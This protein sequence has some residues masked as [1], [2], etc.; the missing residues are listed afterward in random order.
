MHIHTLSY[1]SETTTTTL[2]S[3]FGSS[4]GHSWPGLSQWLS[5]PLWVWVKA[6]RAARHVWPDAFAAQRVRTCCAEDVGSSMRRVL[7]RDE[8]ATAVD[9]VQHVP[10]E[11]VQNRDGEQTVAVPVPAV[12]GCYR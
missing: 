7:S 9:D 4:R 8:A 2:R 10:K 1:A 12:H 5:H 11:R 3:H 6:T